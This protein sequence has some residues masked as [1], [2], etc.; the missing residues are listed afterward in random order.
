MQLQLQVMPERPAPVAGV[1]PDRVGVA[2]VVR[3]VSAAA[4]SSMPPTNAMQRPGSLRWTTRSFWWWLPNRR[5]R[6]S[7]TSCRRLG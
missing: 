5:T 2:A 7:A 6:W 3:I 4:G 1:D